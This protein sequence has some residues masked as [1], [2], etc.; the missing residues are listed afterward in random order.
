MRKNPILRNIKLRGILFGILGIY[1]AINIAFGSETEVP[2]PK[3]DEFTTTEFEQGYILYEDICERLEYIYIYIYI[4][5]VGY[6]YPEWH[7]GIEDYWPSSTLW[8]CCM[9]FWVYQ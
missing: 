9:Y 1:M 8:L 2:K 7:S 6:L 4:Y 3:D 5:I